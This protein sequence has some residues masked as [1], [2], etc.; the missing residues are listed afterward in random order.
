[1]CDVYTIR[2]IDM[3]IAVDPLRCLSTF[4][5]TGEFLVQILEVFVLCE[6]VPHTVVFSIDMIAWSGLRMLVKQPCCNEQYF[7]EFCL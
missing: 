3:Y 2:M 5:A 7:S 4:I 1:M 6:V